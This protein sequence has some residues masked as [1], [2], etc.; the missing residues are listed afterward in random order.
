MANMKIEVIEIGKI[1]PYANNT[2]THSD[3]QIEQIV[4]SIREFGFTKPILIDEANGIIAGHG[5]HLAAQIAGLTEL[6]CIRLS[7]LSERQ[8]RAY[9]IADNKIAQ[10]SGWDFDKLAEE[11]NYLVTADVDLEIT[12]F[13]EQELAALL[14]DDKSLLPKGNLDGDKIVVAEHERTVGGNADDKAKAYSWKII[15]NADSKSDAKNKL[16]ALT[17]A[18]YTCVILKDGAD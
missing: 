2:R 1:I 15:V 5:A 7:H 12:G 9:I 17:K 13:D 16:Q 11:L 6:P 10:N 14:Q 4:E 3:A 18:G 8:R